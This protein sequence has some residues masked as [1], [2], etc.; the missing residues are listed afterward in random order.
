[1]NPTVAWTQNGSEPLVHY[2]DSDTKRSLRMG[3][4][5]KRT[6]H[7]MKRKRNGLSM[8]LRERPLG[9]GSELKTQIQ[10]LGRSRKIQRQLKMRD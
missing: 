4:G 10:R 6:F 1:M 5:E 3:N 9:Q 2:I 8:M 7:A